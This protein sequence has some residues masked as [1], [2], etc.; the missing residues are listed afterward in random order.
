MNRLA[1]FFESWAFVAIA[2]AALIAYA[3]VGGGGMTR[4]LATIARCGWIE[5]WPAIGLM[6]AGLIAYAFFGGA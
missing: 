4:R 6:W 2:W 3:L 1:R 5:S